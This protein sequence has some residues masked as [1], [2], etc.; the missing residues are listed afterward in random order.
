M[1]TNEVPVLLRE[2]E[3]IETEYRTR[4]KDQHHLADG[5]AA[6]YFEKPSGFEFNAGQY[7]D[8]T[9]IN[10]R[11]T[12]PDGNTRSFSLASSPLEDRLLIVTRL[13]NTAFK[14]ALHGLDH[15]AEVELEGPFGSF[16]L[17]EDASTPAVFLSG[18]IGVAPFV[19]MILSAAKN[20]LRRHLYLFCSNSR[21]ESAPFLKTLQELEKTSFN[22]RFIPTMTAMGKSHEPW[23]GET[24]RIGPEM[25]S[26]HLPGVHAPIFYLAGSP[27]FV[28]AMLKML[29][30]AGADEDD[31]HSED[32][33]G[34]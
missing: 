19:S 24:T 23:T 18:G 25:L 27:H 17:H 32:F 33:V 8:I 1:T 13:R 29:K 11:E 34:Y 10:P 5:T 4:P 9:V 14:R 12:D 31:I 7:V 30:F 3:R 26:K 28:A 15:D 22:F 2:S 21:P 16:T 6:F 20:K